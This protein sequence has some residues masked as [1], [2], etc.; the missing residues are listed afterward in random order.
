MHRLVSGLL[1]YSPPQAG[2]QV[3]SAAS[4]NNAAANSALAAAQWTN[5]KTAGGGG[6]AGAGAKVPARK[7]TDSEYVKVTLMI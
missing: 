1:N 4:Q 7:F 2:H 5:N 3:V 6:G